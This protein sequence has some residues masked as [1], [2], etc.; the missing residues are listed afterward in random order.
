MRTPSFISF[1]LINKDGVSS[2]PGMKPEAHIIMRSMCKVILDLCRANMHTN[3]LNIPFC[4]GEFL[5]LRILM[6]SLKAILSSIEECSQFLQ[7]IRESNCKFFWSEVLTGHINAACYCVLL[8]C[9]FS[10][11]GRKRKATPVVCTLPAW[12][13]KG[14]CSAPPNGCSAR[15]QVFKWGSRV[16][17]PCLQ[18]L[19][20]E[21]PRT[22]SRV[23]LV[24]RVCYVC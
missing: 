15:K 19:Y 23:F 17:S 8:V 11:F 3:S 7:G 22:T 6:H 1:V 21:W 13:R 20:K 12:I 9:I 14:C 24:W 5:S 2:F 16:L 10:M 4:P 18:L